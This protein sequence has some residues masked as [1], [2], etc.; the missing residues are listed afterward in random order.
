MLPN[1][2]ML[3]GENISSNADVL[4]ETIK[5]K[6]G[7]ESFVALCQTQIKEI[8]LVNKKATSRLT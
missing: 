6:P 3:N 5:K 7:P 4:D 2:K 1:L 8:N